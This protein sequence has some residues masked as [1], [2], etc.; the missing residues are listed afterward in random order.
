VL[1][2]AG[3]R[4]GLDPAAAAPVDEFSGAVGAE[5]LYPAL[6]FGWRALRAREEAGWKLIAGERDRLYRPD[7]DPA[8]TRDVAAEHPD[9]VARLRD[10]LEESA[11]DARMRAAPPPRAQGPDETEALRSLG[12][13]SGAGLDPDRL[14]DVFRTGPDPADRI[15]LLGDI[16]RGIT[17]LEG[18][19]PAA[20]AALLTK[21][22]AQ[23]PGNRLALE[24]LGRAHAADGR[25][26]DARRVLTRAL[27]LGP[28]PI[29]VHL[30]LAEAER[31]LGALDAAERAIEQA[32]VLEPGSVAARQALAAVF[33][34]REDAASAVRV[35]EEAAALRPKSAPV[36]LDLARAYEAQGRAAEA[37]EAR[38]RVVELDPGGALGAAARTGLVHG[39]TSG[40]REP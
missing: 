18:G 19:R 4:G 12:Y 20:A 33:L 7:E 16:N 24:Y 1:A 26:D 28:N 32:L 17:E 38:R 13:L 31:R 15:A 29:T 22:V 5:S 37:A 34:D 10:A 3:V 23:D 35:L 40:R 6:N 36:H 39:E 14:D 30:D 2:L 21:V 9:V 25:F 11:K 8:E 27:A